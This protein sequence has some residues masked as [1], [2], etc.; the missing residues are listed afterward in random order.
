MI[1]AIIFDLDGTLV[2]SLNDLKD[3]INQALLKNN[4]Q[5]QYNYQETKMLIG[6]GI[7]VLCSRALSYI[8][9]QVEDEEKLYADFQKFYKINQLNHTAAYPNVEETLLALKKLGIK[10][11]ILSNKREENTKIIVKKIFQDGLF[12]IVIGQRENVPLKPDPTSLNLL[13]KELDIDLEQILYVGD[14]DTDMKTALNAKVKK[15]A[16][17]Y[18]YRSKEILEIYQPEYMIDSFNQILDIVTKNNL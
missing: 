2:D 15:V 10:L 14:S 12:D 18:G 8:D 9:H 11:A 13:I 3:S 16:V 4:Y 1:K 17:T 7:R 6:S 5:R